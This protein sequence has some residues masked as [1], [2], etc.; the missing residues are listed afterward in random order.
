MTVNRDLIGY[1]AGMALQ[2]RQTSRGLPQGSISSPIL[3]NLYL[4][5]IETCIPLP[6][7]ILMYADDVA[8]YCSH[9]S[10]NYISN[11]LNNALDNL[12]FFWETLDC[13]FRRLNLYI[14]SFRIRD[15]EICA[16]RCA[17]VILR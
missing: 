17:L 5:L 12:S 9:Q 8:I 1:V 14:R 7:H 2:P 16:C 6:V 15:L 4:A 10:S 11:H 3:F 13:Q